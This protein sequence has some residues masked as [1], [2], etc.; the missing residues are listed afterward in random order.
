MRG[1]FERKGQ[2]RERRGRSEGKIQRKEDWARRRE[3]K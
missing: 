3:R 1:S 2:K